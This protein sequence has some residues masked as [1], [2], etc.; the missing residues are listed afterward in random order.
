[1]KGET[2][3]KEEAIKHTVKV[4]VVGK[5]I[6][7]DKPCVIASRGET[8]EWVLEGGIPFAVV[9]KA[10]HSP[11][12]WAAHSAPGHGKP[13]EVKVRRDAAPGVYP[14]AFCV[15]VRDTLVVD[16]PDIIIQPPKGRG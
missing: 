9:V 4:S 13:L 10:R 12:A 2:V 16:D 5:K 15:C 6:T 11:L 8:I 7:Y 3:M 1:M 14:Y